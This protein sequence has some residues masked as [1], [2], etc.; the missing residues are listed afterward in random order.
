M[1]TEM[2]A[3]PLLT[4]AADTAVRRAHGNEHQDVRHAG[5]VIQQPWHVVFAAIC[6]RKEALSS[7]HIAMSAAGNQ[8]AIR[9]ASVPKRA[10]R[11]SICMQQCQPYSVQVI[12]CL[13]CVERGQPSGWA[14]WAA[15]QLHCSCSNTIGRTIPCWLPVPLALANHHCIDS[16]PSSLPQWPTVLTGQRACPCRGAHL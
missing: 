12:M 16:A 7:K 5:Q 4:D 6:M 1:Y 9:G 13:E 14:H 8:A 10:S 2:Q 11:H 3:Q 15:L